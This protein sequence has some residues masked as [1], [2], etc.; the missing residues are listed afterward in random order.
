MDLSTLIYGA[1]CYRVD[2]PSAGRVARLG[3]GPTQLGEIGPIGLKSA[4]HNTIL[5]VIVQGIQP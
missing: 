3:M 4:L 2:Y 5:E 1:R